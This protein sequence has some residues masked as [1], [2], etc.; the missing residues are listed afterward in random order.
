MEVGIFKA[1]LDHGISVAILGFLLW[2]IVK[3]L[4]DAHI[5]VIRDIG[6]S[7]KDGNKDRD[8]QFHEIKG[9]IHSAKK[10]VISEIKNLKS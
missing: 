2:Y 8:D 3:P 7:I 9:E 4:V 10:E 5:E 6:V 1:L